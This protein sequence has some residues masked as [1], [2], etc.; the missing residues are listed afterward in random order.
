MSRNL[1]GLD[2]LHHSKTAAT[3][4]FVIGIQQLL[5]RAR[6]WQAEAMAFAHDGRKIA[7]ANN[8]FSR[9]RRDAAEGEHILSR[10]IDFD[11]LKA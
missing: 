3:I 6:A 11:P 1:L 4:L 9:R 2:A 8:F 7:D 5:V 10:V